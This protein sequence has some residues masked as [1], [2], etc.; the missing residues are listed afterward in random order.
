MKIGVIGAGRLGIC[1]ALLLEKAGY[2]VLVSDVREDYVNSLNEREINTR[3]SEVKNLL[4]SVKNFRAT[5]D[6]KEVILECD[7]I[8]TLVAT[9]S[10]PDGSY[11]VSSVWQVVNDFQECDHPVHGKSLVVGCT[12]NPGD[13]EQFQSQLNVFGVDVFYNP[14]F[15]AQ[16]TIVRDLQ[17][18]D[19]VLVG[20]PEGD[21]KSL[22]EEIY[23]KIQV[24]EPKINF[25]SLTAA[26]VVKLA[27][28]CYLTTK[29]SYAN[30]VGEVLTKSGLESEIDNVLSSIGNDSRIG[31]KFLKYGYGFGGPCL[32]RDNRSFAAYAQK[33]G[34][35]YNLGMIT[36]S[37]NNEHSK[38]LKNYFIEKNTQNLPFAFHYITYKKGTDIL[39]ESQQYRLCHDLIG[40]NYKVYVT[41]YD[42]IDVE[43]RDRL[44]ALY[45]DGLIFAIPNEEVFWID[46]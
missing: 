39:T 25:M 7:L 20:G 10:L 42:M 4:K 12:T 24:T 18:A 9:P 2:E 21:T 14:E 3:E 30:M 40:E 45:G 32:P 34:L 35:E 23:H 44:E 17:Y 26:E 29:I 28:N 16:G 41:D 37:F 1:F 8:Y 43:V 46:L 33:L 31:N 38:F 22:I 36:D 6:N 19:M 27:I 11:D 15:I 13:C 5:T